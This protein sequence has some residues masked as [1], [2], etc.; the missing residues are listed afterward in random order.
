MS[1]H[2]LVSSSRGF[3]VAFLCFSS[4]I[5]FIFFLFFASPRERFKDYTTSQAPSP[6]SASLEKD[7]KNVITCHP[8]DFV[9]GRWSR[10]PTA[11][12]IYSAQDALR[13]SGILGCASNREYGWHLG[14]EWGRPYE[15]FPY[16]EWRGNVSAYD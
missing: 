12:P 4:S 10:R 15:E 6:T 13:A 7:G 2:F 9:S 8:N 16:R 3:L 14:L 5:V 1:P 11:K